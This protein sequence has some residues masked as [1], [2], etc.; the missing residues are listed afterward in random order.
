MGNDTTWTY[1]AAPDKK[2]AAE[3]SSIKAKKRSTE[4]AQL[5]REPAKPNFAA[6]DPKFAAYYAN[7][8]ALSGFGAAMI[9]DG[10]GDRGT[11]RRR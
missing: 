4:Q 5:D 3:W 10:D 1:I 11:S 7:I 9:E 6:T 2:I 8:A